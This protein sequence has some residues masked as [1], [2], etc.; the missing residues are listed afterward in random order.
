MQYAY[1]ILIRVGKN[2]SCILVIKFTIMAQTYHPYLG[3]LYYFDDPVEKI[4]GIPFSVSDGFVA[5][6]V[7]RAAEVVQKE[8]DN[9]FY[10]RIPIE[11]ENLLADAKFELQNCLDGSKRYFR[12]GFPFNLLKQDNKIWLCKGS[13]KQIGDPAL[14]ED[15]PISEITYFDELQQFYFN[16]TRQQLILF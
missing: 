3:L 13:L 7:Y 1:F 11:G 8:N 16:E 14:K 12:E 10:E 4:M 9:Q 15:A 2:N 5:W 6:N